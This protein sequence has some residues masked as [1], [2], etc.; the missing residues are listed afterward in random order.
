MFIV[1]TGYVLDVF[2]LKGIDSSLPSSETKQKKNEQKDRG[3]SK[4]GGPWVPT[5]P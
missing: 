1:R 5:C 4:T 2:E 3:P